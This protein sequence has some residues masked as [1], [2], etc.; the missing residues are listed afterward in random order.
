VYTYDAEGN[1]V[2][3]AHAGDVT[4]FT[5]DYRNRLTEAVRT[6]GSTVT[7]VKFT[8][9][10][11]DRRIGKAVNGTETLGTVYDGDN[12]Y[13]D[14]T[15]PTGQAVMRYLYGNAVDQLFARYNPAQSSQPVNWYLTDNL[16]S[17][18]QIVDPTGVHG[19]LR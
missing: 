5:W 9:D 17:V 6:Q 19:Q 3:K 1:L 8:Y 16:G 10:V 11:F 14:F 2:S 4:T 13:A 15:S 12:A 7:D 18:R